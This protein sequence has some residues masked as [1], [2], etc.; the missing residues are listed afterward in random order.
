MLLGFNPKLVYLLLYKGAEFFSTSTDG[1]VLWWDVR[2]LS[3]PTESLVL[4]PEKNGSIVGGTALDYEP[5]MVLNSLIISQRNLWL[6]VKVEVYL[7]AIRKQRIQV[8]D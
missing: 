7:Y 6:P 5:T 8:K 3:E 2:K 1:Q 4:D